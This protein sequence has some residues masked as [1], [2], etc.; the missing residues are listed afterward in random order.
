M[1]FNVYVDVQLEQYL[2]L[3][4]VAAL[5]HLYLFAPFFFICRFC[6][7]FAMPKTSAQKDLDWGMLP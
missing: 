4:E 6:L 7:Q 3:P 2:S 1:N 5:L